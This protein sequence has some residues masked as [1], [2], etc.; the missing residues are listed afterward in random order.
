MDDDHLLLSDEQNKITSF[1]DLILQDGFDETNGC[2]LFNCGPV[3]TE[4]D[5]TP[6][7]GRG[8]NGNE[9]ERYLVLTCSQELLRCFAQRYNQRDNSILQ[10]FDA[11][12]TFEYLNI[13]Q[14]MGTEAALLLMDQEVAWLEVSED[15]LAI[16]YDP[17]GA[18]FSLFYVT[19]EGGLRMREN[20]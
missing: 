10:L 15:T 19:F 14:T 3:G 11:Q 16:D 13:G 18:G 20:V 7:F 12:S 9:Y 1:I 8:T 2:E 6:A 4:G 17:A 5:K